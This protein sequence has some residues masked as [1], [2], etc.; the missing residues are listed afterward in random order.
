MDEQDE[1]QLL[2]LSIAE[3]KRAHT[4]FHTLF[5]K[6]TPDGH[7][8]RWMTNTREI[9]AVQLRLENLRTVIEYFEDHI[10]H[11]KRQGS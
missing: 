6:V 2:Q 10:K 4:L 5:T 11:A 3:M 9:N 7:Q 8:A 1:K